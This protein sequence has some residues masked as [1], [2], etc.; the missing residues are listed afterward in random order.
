MPIVEM[1]ELSYTVNG[2]VYGTI[3]TK[4]SMVVPQTIIHRIFRRPNCS[5]SGC[6]HIRT[7]STVL[8]RY[9]YTHVHS[10]IVCNSQN[11]EVTQMSINR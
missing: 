2:S 11:I 4:S 5:P 6:I 7:E 3:T 9:L 10:V 8:K 1:L